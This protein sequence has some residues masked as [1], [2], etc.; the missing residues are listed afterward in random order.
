[1]LLLGYLLTG[2]IS[3]N[4]GD[5]KNK[6]QS[7]AWRSIVVILVFFVS[8]LVVF[9]VWQYYK[10]R[11][12][13]KDLKTEFNNLKIPAEW[14]LVSES[15]NKGTLGLF[16][17]SISD[18]PCPV[19]AKNYEQNAA[20]NPTV[21]KQTVENILISSGYKIVNTR[22]NSCVLDLNQKYFCYAEG[23]KNKIAALVSVSKELD[24]DIKI[25]SIGLESKSAAGLN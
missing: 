2:I 13:Y 7:S 14:K 18:N 8:L 15:G 6:K 20:P 12:N 16:C 23:Y 9:F 4:M 21:D 11:P 10:N 3:S 22:Y 17:F 25:L 24:R 5:K 1:M 19:Y